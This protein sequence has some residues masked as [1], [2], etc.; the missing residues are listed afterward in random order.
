MKAGTTMNLSLPK[1]RFRQELARLIF[2]FAAA[3]CLVTTG[4]ASHYYGPPPPPAAYAQTPPVVE[5]ADH[6]GFRA[7]AED[8]ARDAANGFG[9][10]PKRDRKFIETVGYDPAAG[11]FPVYRDYFRTAYLR[12]YEQG[13][14]HR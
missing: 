8:G 2:P 6:R 1:L 9:Y 12:G 7:G 13:F 3:A 11:P 5:E 10:H 14:Y 4:C